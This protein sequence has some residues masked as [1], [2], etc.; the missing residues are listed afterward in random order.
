MTATYYLQLKKHIKAG[1]DSVADASKPTYDPKVFLKRVP[2]LK[3]LMI[4]EK[5]K[6]A[7]KATKPPAIIPKNGHSPSLNFNSN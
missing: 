1:G 2:N 6:T 4:E 5:E 3:N 7:A